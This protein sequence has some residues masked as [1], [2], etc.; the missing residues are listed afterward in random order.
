MEYDDS[1]NNIE[2]DNFEQKYLL[3]VIENIKRIKEAKKLTLEDLASLSG[4]SDNHLSKIC[5]TSTK[6]SN[7]VPSLHTLFKIAFSLG[8]S[9]DELLKENPKID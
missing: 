3:L 5:T 9:P 4:I 7:R 1:K 8:V 6:S 2:R